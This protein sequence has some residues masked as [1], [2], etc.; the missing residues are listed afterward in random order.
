VAETSI[1][2]EL[3]DQILTETFNVLAKEPS[4]GPTQVPELKDLAQVGLTDCSAEIMRILRK[5][6]NSDEAA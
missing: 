6:G 4:F 5:E 3:L 1:K 2:S